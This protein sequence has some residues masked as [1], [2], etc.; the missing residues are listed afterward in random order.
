MK[1]TTALWVCGAAIGCMALAGCGGGDHN[2][3]GTASTPTP[4]APPVSV[5]T[6]LDTAEVLA[7][8]QTRTSD[9][10]SPFQVDGG[11]VTVTPTDDETGTPIPVDGS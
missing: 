2:S 7:I 11:A 8:V 4:P 10:S 1:A 5:P 3:S 9:T 6:T